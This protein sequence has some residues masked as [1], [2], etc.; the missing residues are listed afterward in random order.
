MMKLTHDTLVESVVKRIARSIKP[1]RIYLFGSRADG[2]AR[3]DSDVDLLIIYSGP[4]SKGDLKIRIR[5]LFP[6][7]DFSM[8]LLVLTPDEFERQKGIANTIAREVNERG[9]IAY[10]R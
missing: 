4:L 1:E 10:E 9:V 5:K 7:P 6:L 2:T 3:E 8:D